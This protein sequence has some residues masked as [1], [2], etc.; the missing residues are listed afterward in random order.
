MQTIGALSRQQSFGGDCL[1]TNAPTYDGPVRVYPP[2]KQARC[3][4]ESAAPATRWRRSLQSNYHLHRLGRLGLRPPSTRRQ[5]KMQTLF[6]SISHLAV[7]RR[8]GW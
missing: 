5:V 6:A 1:L 2:P 3:A 8:G 4:L 7:A